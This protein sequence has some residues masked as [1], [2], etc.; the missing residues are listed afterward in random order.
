M[1][2]LIQHFEADFLG[3][4]ATKSLIQGKKTLKTFTHATQSYIYCL[5]VAC[6]YALLNKCSFKSVL[7]KTQ[8]F[9]I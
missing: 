2:S 5:L 4:S 9:L 8:Y 1:V 3:K 6:V 7:I